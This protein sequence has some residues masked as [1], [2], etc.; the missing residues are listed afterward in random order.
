[1]FFEMMRKNFKS[2]INA[3]A[4]LLFILIYFPCF[5]TVG[6]VYRE[7]GSFVAV[8]QVLYTTVLAWIVAV[9]FYQI[10]AGHDVLWISV[11]VLLLF[12]VMSLFKI[13]GSFFYSNKD[14]KL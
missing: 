14:A 13:V 8:S 11:A 10:A 6:V 5:A 2:G 1:M 4:Y 9:L 7:A 3:Y 12:A